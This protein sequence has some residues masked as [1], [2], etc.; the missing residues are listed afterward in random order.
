MSGPSNVPKSNPREAQPCGQLRQESGISAPMTWLRRQIAVHEENVKEKARLR[1][2]INE[3]M[4][5]VYGLINFENPLDNPK[6]H[7]LNKC[8][9]LVISGFPIF[10]YHTRGRHVDGRYYPGEFYL[11]KDEEIKFAAVH[12]AVHEAVDE[13]G[14]RYASPFP[15]NYA[16]LESP[17]YLLSASFMRRRLI[18]GTLSEDA[19]ATLMATAYYYSR[20]AP[21]E[22]AYLSYAAAMPHMKK[23][24]QHRE[25]HDV[26]KICPV[27]EDAR[28]PVFA[29]LTP[30]SVAKNFASTFDNPKLAIKVMH[31]TLHDLVKMTVLSDREYWQ[32]KA[33]SVR[34][35]MKMT[36]IGV[37]T[38]MMAFEVSD[39]DS[40]K[41]AQL[42]LLED[43][44][45][46]FD[47]IGRMSDSSIGHILETIK[48]K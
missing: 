45:V 33:D 3:G 9:D 10:G 21:S 47:C 7:L 39:R 23:L 44:K 31:D 43:P 4:D 36:F 48:P 46:M 1:E 17:A 28:L 25:L 32:L 20:H 41:A 24:A 11:C 40:A 35:L 34:W 6:I 38:A 37:V 15:L 30:K 14:R 13:I 12:E 16:L 42:L 29:E 26:E 8:S 2:Y 22:R 27:F 5:Y 18:N 19:D